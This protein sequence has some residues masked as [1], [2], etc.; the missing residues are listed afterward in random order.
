MAVN[1]SIVRIQAPVAQVWN[2][3][4]NPELVKQWQYGSE[5]ITDWQ[6]GRPIRFR[7]QWE[8]KVLEQWGQILAINPFEFIQ[9]SLF[10]PRPDLKDK[11][12]NYFVM[13]YLLTLEGEFTKLEIRQQD[14]RPGAKQE[15]PQGEDNPVLKGLKAL[16]ES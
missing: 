3:L 6:V 11:P 16:L 15:A 7:T 9:Y 5:L 14:N 12:E 2:A 8:G 1:S 10:A 4:V 13:S